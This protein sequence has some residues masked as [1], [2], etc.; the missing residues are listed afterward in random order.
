LIEHNGRQ[1]ASLGVSFRELDIT[2]DPLPPGEVAFLRQVLQHLPNRQIQ[3]TV[4]KIPAVYR[5]LVLTEHLPPS[6]D[7]VPNLD[8]PAGP[9]TRIDA[10]GCPSGVV[11]TESPFNLKALR[12]TVLCEIRD[13]LGV[14][15]TTLYEFDQ[16]GQS[17]RFN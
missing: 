14:I 7:F 8:K 6:E 9:H 16:S 13:P 10:T 17:T 11:L 3:A 4:A 15:R 2:T 12:A 1:F 5:Y